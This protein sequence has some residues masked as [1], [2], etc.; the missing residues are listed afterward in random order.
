MCRYVFRRLR[1]QHFYHGRDLNRRR[2]VHFRYRYARIL[3]DYHDV[4]IWE[5]MLTLRSSMKGLRRMFAHASFKGDRVALY[6]DNHAQY[7]GAI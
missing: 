6:H 4:G 3:N 2:H 7:L 1:L 5:S